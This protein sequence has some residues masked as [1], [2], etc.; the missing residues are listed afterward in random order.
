M[1]GFCSRSKLRVSSIHTELLFRSI[2]EDVW[3]LNE[4]LS[5]YVLYDDWL[6]FGVHHV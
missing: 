3:L 1:V 5:K 4:V 6:Y 2:L